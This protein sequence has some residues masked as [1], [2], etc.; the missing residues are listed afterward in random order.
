MS[1][2]SEHL[3]ELDGLVVD[4]RK[5]E[6]CAASFRDVDDSQKDGNAYAVD[7][8]G[9]AE[10][11]NQSAAPAI[12]LPATF[13]LDFFPG[14]L[15]QVIASIYNRGGANTVR[16]YQLATWC[17]HSNRS[18]LLRMIVIRFFVSVAA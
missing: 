14:Q 12:Q 6:A 18:L 2:E 9:I 11:D 15:I 4:V 3:K 13:T 1:R 8:L 16:A 10:I 5:G 17:I 7:E